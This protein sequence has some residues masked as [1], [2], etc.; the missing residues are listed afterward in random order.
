MSS[1]LAFDA[2]CYGGDFP[3]ESKPWEARRWCKGDGKWTKWQPCT[4]AQKAE[5]TKR[6]EN[7]QFRA[8]RSS[9]GGGQ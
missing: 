3:K 5:W 8:A 4:E 6:D 1:T 9:E 7:F 2:A